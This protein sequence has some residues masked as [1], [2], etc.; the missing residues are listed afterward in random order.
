MIINKSTKIPQC[1]TDQPN[2][3]NMHVLITNREVTVHANNCP[4]HDTKYYSATAE[5]MTKLLY[6]SKAEGQIIGTL[7]SHLLYASY[8]NTKGPT[9]RKPPQGK[10]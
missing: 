1:I 9:K 3:K 8:E 6:S 10:G 7:R 5:S 2:K 4:M